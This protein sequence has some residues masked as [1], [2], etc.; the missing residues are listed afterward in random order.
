MKLSRERI[1]CAC[2]IDNVVTGSVIVVHNKRLPMDVVNDEYKAG[3][4]IKNANVFFIT[5]HGRVVDDTEAQQIA[6]DAGQCEK[7]RIKGKL[8]ATDLWPRD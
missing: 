6:V 7:F 4:P 2:V 8:C 3:R 5:T 1:A